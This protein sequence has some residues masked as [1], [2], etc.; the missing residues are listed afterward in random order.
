M[1]EATVKLN[2]VEELKAKIQLDTAKIA[3]T[4]KEIND[5]F[6]PKHLLGQEL[7]IPE[8]VEHG[9]MLGEYKE[10]SKALIDQG[11]FPRHWA[12]TKNVSKNMAGKHVKVE[13]IQLLQI[14]H[15]ATD[16]LVWVITAVVKNSNGEYGLRKVS[17]YLF[18]KV[19]LTD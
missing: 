17:T 13:S 19:E 5:R 18:D 8:K 4:Y 1:K 15:K 2:N 14:D 6:A 7:V 3:L 12:Y 9:S 10:K 16:T 11:V